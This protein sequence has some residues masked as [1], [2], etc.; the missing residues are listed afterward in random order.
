MFKSRR[1]RW[2]GHIAG[3]GQKWN[4]YRLLV[5]KPEERRPL[6]RPRCRWL[7]DIEMDLGEIGWGGAGWIDLAQDMNRW[8]APVDSVMNLR[9]P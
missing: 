3:M 5:G 2:A 1:M 6:G 8:R 4:A 9:V 7:V